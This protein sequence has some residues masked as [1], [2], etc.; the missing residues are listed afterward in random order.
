M[1]DKLIFPIPVVHVGPVALQLP[2][3]IVL[4]G[5]WAA[6]WVAAC[7]ARIVGL[8][9][10][11]IYNP[12]FYAAVAGIIG[13]RLWY[14]A[15]HWA[16]FAGDPLGIISLNL[17][18]FDAT[19]GLIIGISVGAIYA[20]RKKL[21]GAQW[22]DALTPGAAAMLAVVS[23]ANLF[24]GAAYGT[25][26][27]LP[28]AIELW[29]AERHPTQIYEMLAMLAILFVLLVTLRRRPTLGT[30]TLLFLALYSGQRVFLEA[31]RADS[32]L[33]PGG[34]R[35]AQVAGLVVLGVSL[36]MLSRRSVADPR[37]GA[38]SGLSRS[39]SQLPVR[40]RSKDEEAV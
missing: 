5:F 40:E 7:G 19:A 32:A 39:Q 36:V 15:V 13:A 1:L 24:S 25:P 3:L 29:D 34:W 14:V 22:L 4:F 27:T 9:D 8:K 20:W 12:G 38:V 26:T 31:F 21:L 17:T 6:L 37:Q 28:W 30:A 33:L 16:A 35:A 10:D 11:D 18:T 23:L 2:G